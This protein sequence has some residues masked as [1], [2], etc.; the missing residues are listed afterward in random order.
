[1]KENQ[2]FQ[3]SCSKAQLEFPPGSCWIVFTDMVSHAVLSGQFALEQTFLVPRGALLTPDEAP[4]YV[5]ERLC[6]QILVAG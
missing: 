5:L 3:Q 2:E 4:L 1:M 6:G